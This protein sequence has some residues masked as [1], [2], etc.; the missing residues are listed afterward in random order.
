MAFMIP[1]ISPD[2]P[3]LFAYLELEVDNAISIDLANNLNSLELYKWLSENNFIGTPETDKR[4]LRCSSKV[5]V[6]GCLKLSLLTSTH[7]E[8]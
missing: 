4:S 3:L 7:L 1:I 8:K 6:D 5:L 2:R